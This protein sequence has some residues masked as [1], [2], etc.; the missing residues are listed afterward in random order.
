M[1]TPRINVTVT[2]GR[3]HCIDVY[4]DQSPTATIHV[5]G[6]NYSRGLA[7]VAPYVQVEVGPLGVQLT[8]AQARRLGADLMREADKVNPQDVR[9]E[10]DHAA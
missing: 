8:P 2:D 3:V 9:A 10:V 6:F 1:D 7:A 4:L 5:D